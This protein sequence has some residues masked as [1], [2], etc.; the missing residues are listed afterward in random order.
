MLKYKFRQEFGISQE[1]CT[2]IKEFSVQM[3]MNVEGIADSRVMSMLDGF[4]CGFTSL[5]ENENRSID[6]EFE[7]LNEKFMEEG[8]RYGN[9]I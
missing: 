4:S 2:P 6:R 1:D 9:R 3:Y 8:E 7:Q 5:M